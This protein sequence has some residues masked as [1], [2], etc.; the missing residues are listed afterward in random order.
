M[1]LLTQL[2]VL[3]TVK[4]MKHNR[5]QVFVHSLLSECFRRP[6]N[7]HVKMSIFSVPKPF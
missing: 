6:E 7:F 4:Q 1:K 3:Q 5:E 2:V